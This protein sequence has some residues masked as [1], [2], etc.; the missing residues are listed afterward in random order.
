MINKSTYTKT[1]DLR[2]FNSTRFTRYTYYVNYAIGCLD[3]K[4]CRI[5]QVWSCSVLDSVSKNVM[6][7]EGIRTRFRRWDFILI[8]ME[9]LHDFYNSPHFLNKIHILND[10]YL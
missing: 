10:R 3:K 7:P 1:H 9:N 2:H 5:F 4:T 8:L 6:S